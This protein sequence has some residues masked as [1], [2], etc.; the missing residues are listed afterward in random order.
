MIYS[1]IGSLQK[2][3]YNFILTEI[4]ILK[5]VNKE[6]IRS[7]TY[8]KNKGQKIKIIEYKSEIALGYLHSISDFAL[9]K[10]DENE[11]PIVKEHYIFNKKVKPQY[12]E[13]LST[14]IDIG[15]GYLIQ[16]EKKNEDELIEI[17]ELLNDFNSRDDDF[18]FIENILTKYGIN[19]YHL[20]EFY[21]HENI[22]FK[23]NLLKEFF[24][25]DY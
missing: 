20:K 9:V 15:F 22:D 2:D 1:N 8:K 17:K 7:F 21:K 24:I 10:F 6:V 18:K 23:D 12:F 3:K 11:F 16:V 19:S 5:K 4:K 13:D 25:L 14:S